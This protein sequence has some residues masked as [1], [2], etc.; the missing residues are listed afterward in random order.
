MAFDSEAVHS[1][2]KLQ[3]VLHLGAFASSSQ[4]LSFNQYIFD[5]TS[6][7]SRNTLHDFQAYLFFVAF[8]F[9]QIL[10]QRWSQM[11]KNVSVKFMWKI[12]SFL[13]LTFLDSSLYKTD[14]PLLNV[15][16]RWVGDNL[17]SIHILHIPYIIWLE[18]TIQQILPNSLWSLIESSWDILTIFQA[19]V[20]AGRFLVLRG[21]CVQ[22]LRTKASCL[23][24]AC[25]RD[26]A[27]WNLGPIAFSTL[28][29]TPAKVGSLSFS[30]CLLHPNSSKAL[31]SCSVTHSFSMT[32]YKPRSLDQY[33]WNLNNTKK[34]KKHTLIPAVSFDS[35]P[36]KKRHD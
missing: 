7:N 5:R 17:V 12:T 8:L 13:V 23:R 34:F 32:I 9:S 21:V 28:M 27:S 19:N 35:R 10:T 29:T 16:G 26:T 25:T 33:N 18:H 30:C 24:V 36:L 11:Q 22:I 2:R 1:S 31:V 20:D 4:S 14:I 15:D 6:S 3:L